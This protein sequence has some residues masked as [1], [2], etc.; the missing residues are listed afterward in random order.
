L[1]N[2]VER[3]GVIAGYPDGTFRGDRALTRYE[4]AAGLNAVMDTISDLIAA[5][6]DELPTRQDLEVLRRLQDEFAAE[7][8]DLQGRVGDLEERTTTLESQQF[9]PI[10]RLNGQAIFG[11]SAA[12]GGD[13]PG[14]GNGNLSFTHS[15]EMQ[16]SGSFSGRDVLRIG[17][18]AGSGGLGFANPQNLNTNMALQSYQTETFNRFELSTLEYRFAVGDRLV[19][20]VQPAGFDLTSILTPNSIFSSSSRGAISRFGAFNPVFRIGGL[21]AGLGVDWLISNRARLQVG[22]GARDANDPSNG[23]FSSNHR[24]F[25]VQLLTRPFYGVTTGIAYVNA[26]DQNGFLNTFTGS[27]NADI[28]GGFNERS[29]IHA[30]SGTLQWEVTP[31]LILGTW[32]GLII[33]DS[34]ESDAAA[35]STTY[36]FSMGFP[37]P[38]GRQGDLLGIM[39]G[40]PPR[41][42]EGILIQNDDPGAGLHY[43]A[44]YRARIN[45]HISIT[46]GIFFVTD[47]GHIPNNNDIFVAALRTVFSF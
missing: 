47:P 45:D 15:S 24:A 8:T 10:M 42:R 14:T 33:T 34:L 9:S 29:A 3:Y 39:V 26:F 36:M 19:V 7:L 37:D 21:D 5:G 32:G 22:Y 43:E 40:Q 11:L 1:Q 4:F 16:I 6:M 20:T 2:L 31:G 18:T 35:L 25:G 12:G 27:N 23:L 46:P 28:S 41:L 44:F 30:F 38:F 13:P 17:L